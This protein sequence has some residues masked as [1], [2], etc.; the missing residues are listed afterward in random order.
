MSCLA[1]QPVMQ[2]QK[3]PAPPRRSLG[4]SVG[5]VNEETK[6]VSEKKRKLNESQ[7]IAQL[8]NK[9]KKLE[10]RK[11]K[12]KLHLERAIQTSDESI[13]KLDQ[14]LFNNRV[15]KTQLLVTLQARHVIESYEILKSGS[16][17]I[18]I[19]PTS[20]WLKHRFCK[21]KC[22]DSTNVDYCIKIVIDENSGQDCMIRDIHEHS[23]CDVD[24]KWRELR[25][26]LKQDWHIMELRDQQRWN[27]KQWIAMQMLEEEEESD[28]SSDTSGDDEEENDDSSDTSGDYS[29]DD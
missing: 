15:E 16:I 7:Q 1:R 5:R 19:K 12:R 25:A 28:D 6:E 10:R 26:L 20:P 13:E 22:T 14:R 8:K 2:R 23:S 27:N 9:M 4:I 24:Y 29:C 18:R 3:R 11:L 21:C 17:E